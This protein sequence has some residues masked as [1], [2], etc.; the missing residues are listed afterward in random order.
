M[1]IPS[2]RTSALLAAVVSIALGPGVQAASTTFWQAAFRV[3]GSA[4]LSFS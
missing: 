1:R 2:L 4:A 3:A